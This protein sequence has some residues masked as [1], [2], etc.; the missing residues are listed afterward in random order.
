MISGTQTLFNWSLRSDSRS[1]YPHIVR[2]GFAGFM[3]LAVMGAW[4]Q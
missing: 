1:I 3:L 4:G 2:A